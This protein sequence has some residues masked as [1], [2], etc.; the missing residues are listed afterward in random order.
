MAASYEE[1]I[2]EYQQLLLGKMARFHV[3]FKNFEDGGTDYTDVAVNKSD[4]MQRA[5]NFSANAKEVG[6]VWKYA[7]ENLF[8][9]TPEQAVDFIT[10]ELVEKY[11]LNKTFIGVKSQMPSFMPDYSYFLQF[12]YPD[13]IKYDVESQAIEIYKKI[14]KLEKYANDTEKITFPKGFFTDIYGI[15]R[16]MVIFNYAINLY[17]G[18]LTT[19]QK[20]EFFANEDVAR[21]WLRKKNLYK[22]LALKMYDTALDYFH[23][24]F[25]PE[26]RSE[27][28]YQE[29]LI[30]KNSEKA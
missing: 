21:K 15:Q 10:P 2:Y 4:P 28:L 23:D 29:C 30:K 3:A 17:H 1:C 24:M 6:Y 22:P 13:K 27:K 20:Y 25:Q 26:K 9:L 19:S 5:K 11:M 14:Q 18:D 16:L 12:A 7:C 8:N